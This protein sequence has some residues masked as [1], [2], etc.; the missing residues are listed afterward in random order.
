VAS[1][2]TSRT[3]GRRIKA[4]EKDP[5]VLYKELEDQLQRRDKARGKQRTRDRG[6]GGPER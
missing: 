6:D 4:T 2:G 1:D 5:A 3:Q